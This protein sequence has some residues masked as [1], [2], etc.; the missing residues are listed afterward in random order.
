MP[1]FRFVS[2]DWFVVLFLVCVG[3]PIWLVTGFGSVCSWSGC[4]RRGWARAAEEPDDERD[5]DRVQDDVQ[6]E[7]H[8]DEGGGPPRRAQRPR[9][10]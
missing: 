6:G 5:P 10:E 1:A 3:T 4:L 8:R 9:V 7:A 2:G